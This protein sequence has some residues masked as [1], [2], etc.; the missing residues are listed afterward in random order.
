MTNLQVKGDRVYIKQ[1]VHHY[2]ALSS[3]SQNLLRERRS[4][5]PTMRR[6]CFC[7]C[8]PKLWNKQP[9]SLRTITTLNAFKSSFKTYLYKKSSND[10]NELWLLITYEQWGLWW[11]I[12]MNNENCDIWL[13]MKYD[14][15]D[16]LLFMNNE[17]CTIIMC[18]NAVFNVYPCVMLKCVKS[19]EPRDEALYK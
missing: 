11:M 19:L 9:K 2:P 6:S 8:A 17:N 16:D 4:D 1:G 14:N 10:Y 12:D 3:S 15:C 5:D 13:F 18:F 7:L